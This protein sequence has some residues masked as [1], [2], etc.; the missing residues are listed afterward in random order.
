LGNSQVIY[1]ALIAVPV[2]FSIGF[3]CGAAWCA[4]GEPPKLDSFDSI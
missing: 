2:V 4:C 1:L 3:L